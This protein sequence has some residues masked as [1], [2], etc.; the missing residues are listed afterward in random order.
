MYNQWYDISRVTL[1][2]LRKQSKNII[3]IY[4]THD[5][6][7]NN[8]RLAYYWESFLVCVQ[9]HATK[10]QREKEGEAVGGG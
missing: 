6:Y 7:R 8:V 5:S 3:N 10:R 4:S 9:K 1:Y 2:L